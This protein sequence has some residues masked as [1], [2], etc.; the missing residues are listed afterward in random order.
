MAEAEPLHHAGP[1]VLDQHVGLADEAMHQGDRLGMLQVERE[2][3]LAG[4]E[5]A[6][7]GALAV[8]QRRAQ[9]HVVALGRFDLQHVGAHVGEQAR[10]VRAGQHDREVEDAEAGERVRAT[11]WQAAAWRSGRPFARISAAARPAATRRG[12]DEGLE[13]A[14]HRGEMGAH[15]ARRQL[16]VARA[17]RGEEG[18]AL[19][20]QPRLRL[21]AGGDAACRRTASGSR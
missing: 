19:L 2:A 7:I 8:A 18:A 13:Q 20:D 16:G 14:M 5:L 17:E 15:Q 1:E 21:A 10:A 6:E 3:A 11:V 9:A 4:V 12:V